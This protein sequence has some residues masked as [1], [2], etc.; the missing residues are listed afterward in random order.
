MNK[1]CV[2]T[3]ITG[4]Y[5]ELK[6]PLVIDKKIDY[7]CITN[8]KSLRSKTWK[9]KYIDEDIDNWL[10]ARKVKIMGPSLYLSEYPITIYIDSAFQIINSLEKYIEK[11]CNLDNV[12]MVVVKHEERD[13]IYDEANEVVKLKRDIKDNVSKLMDYYKKEKYPKHNGLLAAGILVRKQTKPVQELM[14]SWWYMVNHWSKRDQLSFNY[15]LW[16]HPIPIQVVDMYYYDNKYFKHD[17]H[18][19]RINFS[20]RTARVYFGDYNNFDYNKFID[21]DYSNNTLKEG[22][23]FKVLNDTDEIWIILDNIGDRIDPKSISVS[24]KCETKTEIKDIYGCGDMFMRESIIRLNGKFKKNTSLTI[25]A[26]IKGND[27]EYL[28]NNI[29]TLDSNIYILKDRIYELEQQLEAMNQKY[30][31]LQSS[32][33]WKITKPLRKATSIYRNL[34]SKKYVSKFEEFRP[35]VEKNKAI[36][37]NNPKDGLKEVV[38]NFF[39]NGHGYRFDLNKPKTFS[40]KLAARKLETNELYTL[41][42]DK[43]QVRDYVKNKIGEKYLVPCYLVTDNFTR[44]QFNSLPNSFVIKT[45]GGSGTLDII[46]DKT[47]TSYKKLKTELDD[48]LEFEHWYIGGEMHY[49]DVSKGI[50]CEKLLLDDDN[51]VP[52]DYKFHVFKNGGDE[53]VFVQVDFDRFEKHSRNVYDEDFNLLD[54]SIAFPNY[55]GEAKKPKNYNEMIKVAKKLA[56]DFDYVRVDLYNVDGYIYFGELTFC[57]GGSYETITPFEKDVE[58]GTYWK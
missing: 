19:S 48:W 25:K 47:K 23:S 33:S 45:A 54:M 4:E 38:M 16:K 1:I 31:A 49:K 15:C 58:W 27:R 52:R 17:F 41:C 7:I 20:K 44:K 29:E 42:S 34:K 53:K 12:D 37:L 57:H 21:I 28:L 13:C 5:D 14:E 43:I 6:E 26:D 32:N 8:N 56:E 11:E 55:K 35:I 46:Y 30:I 36:I 40:E 51:K 39:E 24:K 2:Y 10:L 50:I 22:L 3:V 9:I 18:H